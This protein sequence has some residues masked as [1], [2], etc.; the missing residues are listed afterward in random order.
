[1][2]II[3]YFYYCHSFVRIPFIRAKSRVSESGT[4]RKRTRMK[5]TCPDLQVNPCTKRTYI[6][7]TQIVLKKDKHVVDI[8]S[9]AMY[10]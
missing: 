7:I 5:N 4:K 6:I 10:K 1:M 8:L 3:I 2:A 9:N